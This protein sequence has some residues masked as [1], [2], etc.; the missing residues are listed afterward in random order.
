MTRP[1]ATEPETLTFD[2]QGS[3]KHECDEKA[4]NRVAAFLSGAPVPT[5]DIAARVS[6]EATPDGQWVGHYAYRWWL[7]R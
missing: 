6:Y 3:T 2:Q 5:S 4:L 7:D 1:R